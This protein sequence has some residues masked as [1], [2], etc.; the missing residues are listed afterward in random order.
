M[1]KIGEKYKESFSSST[2]RRFERHIGGSFPK[3]L[4]NFSSHP[5][6]EN[7][8]SLGPLFEKKVIIFYP[9]IDKPREMHFDGVILKI[10]AK[11]FSPFIGKLRE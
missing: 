3:N 1:T 8:V 5:L 10:S 11:V 2:I 4:Q 6:L 9:L 7:K